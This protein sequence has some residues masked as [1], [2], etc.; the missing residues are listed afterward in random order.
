M[1]GITIKLFL[2]M[3]FCNIAAISYSDNL[4]VENITMKQGEAKVI[5][6][7]FNNEKEM[8][9]SFQ[10]NMYLPKG[11]DPKKLTPGGVVREVS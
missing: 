1:K 3:L 5:S 7:N 9:T 6:I 2:V 4:S 10:F 8:Y 11:I